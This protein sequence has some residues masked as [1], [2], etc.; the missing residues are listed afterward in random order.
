MGSSCSQP[1]AV[2]VQPAQEILVLV[3]QINMVS[4][5]SNT[6]MRLLK[7]TLARNS[8]AL[9]KRME[10]YEGKLKDADEA[11][12]ATAIWRAEKQRTEEML[13]RVLRMQVPLAYMA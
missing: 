2:S 4:G 10:I 3:E 13:K 5:H 8:A 1:A 12:P 6:E 11:N 9:K 7:R